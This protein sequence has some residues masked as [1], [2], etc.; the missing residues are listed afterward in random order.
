[1]KKIK[2]FTAILL[3]FTMTTLYAQT[4]RYEIKSG[5]IE[6]KITQSGNMMG[7][8][9]QGS[10][11]AKTA[12]KEWGGIELHTEDSQTVTMGTKERNRITTKIDNE[13]VYNVDFEQK[14]IY[15][16]N[17]QDLMNAEDKQLVMTGKE[18]MASMGGKKIGEEKFM[19]YACE[20]WEMMQVK[21]WL[22]KGVMLKSEA[23]IMGMKNATVATKIAFDVTVP[24]AE[25]QLPDYP[26]KKGPN[27]NDM[28]PQMTPEQMQQMQEMMKNFTQR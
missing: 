16:Q 24:D 27:Q 14:V 23:N 13:K 3:A 25:L 21:V 15:E 7:M 4:K 9:I 22:H 17:M 1:M 11:T 8:Q 20:I 5:I 2:I 26:I 28:M 19:G 6:Y 12:F 18:F 10:G